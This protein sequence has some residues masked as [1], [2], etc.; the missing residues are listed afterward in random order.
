MHPQQPVLESPR[1][2]LT[3][4]ESPQLRLGYPRSLLTGEESLTLPVQGNKKQPRE[5]APALDYPEQ[6]VGAE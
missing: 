4:E 1:S 2:F 5:H 3:G 6:S